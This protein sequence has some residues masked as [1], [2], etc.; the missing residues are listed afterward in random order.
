MNE[1]PFWR[2]Y[3]WIVAIFC[4][5]SLLALLWIVP[6]TIW[7][8]PNISLGMKVAFNVGAGVLTLLMAPILILTTV[9][10][11]KDGGDAYGASGVIGAIVAADKAARD[12]RAAR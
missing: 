1:Q 12:A 7:F 5:L 10:L 6:V 2:A 9:S 11:G 3:S 8:A 4:A